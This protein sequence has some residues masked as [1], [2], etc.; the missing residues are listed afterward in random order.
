[1]PLVANIFFFFFIVLALIVYIIG[2]ALV[3]YEH[4]WGNVRLENASEGLIM[5]IFYTFVFLCVCYVYLW[6]SDSFVGWCDE[7][8]VWMLGFSVLFIFSLLLALLIISKHYGAG[9]IIATSLVCFLWFELDITP[10]YIISDIREEI[11]SGDY[12]LYDFFD[13]SKK[14]QDTNRHYGMP[15]IGLP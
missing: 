3:I 14:G 13:S 9:F 1:M 4:Y 7:R 5:W 6:M 2:P 12:R 8:I 10:I 11:A 15:W